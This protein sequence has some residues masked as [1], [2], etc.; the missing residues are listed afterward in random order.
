VGG[1]DLG[2]RVEPLGSGAVATAKGAGRLEV[3]AYAVVL[4]A[5]GLVYRA[6]FISQGFNATD[7]GW[8]QAVAR[9][10]VMGQV[11]YRDFNFDF[12]P[13]SIYKEAGLQ[14]L[15]GAAYD[16]LVSR[17]AFA[18]EA[19]LGSVLAFF[20]LRSFVST[21]TAFLLALPTNFFSVLVYAYENYTY[22][23]QILLL[24]SLLLLQSAGAGRRWLAVA[25]GVAA[26]LAALAKPTYAGFVVL[27]LVVALAGARLSPID[28]DRFP[29]LLGARRHWA[30][31]LAGFAA[32][33]GAA[34]LAFTAVGAGGAFVYQSFVYYQQANPLGLGFA[35]WQN[36]PTAFSRRELELLV[37]IAVLLVGASLLPSAWLRRLCALGTPL[38]LL[39]YFYRHHLPADFVPM[40]MGLLLIINAWAVVLTIVV[41]LPGLRDGSHFT[42][43]RDRL[44]PP[45]LPVFALGLQYLAQ[46]TSSGVLYSY[47]GAYLS[48]PTA[49][50]LLLE[51][52]VSA[53]DERAP[54]RMALPALAPALFALWLVVASVNFVQGYVYFDYPRSQLTDSFKTPALA[55]ITS[56][57]DNVARVDGVVAA[58]DRHSRPGDPIFALPDFACLYLLADRRNPTRQDWYESIIL[59]PSIVSQAVADLQRDPPKVVVVQTRYEQDYSHT[60][61]DHFIDYQHT[62]ATQIYQYLFAN[63]HV[64]E[65]VGDINI[66]VPNG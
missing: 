54:A 59:T 39:A 18:V 10:I 33:L 27:V 48:V 55:G 66:L 44:P 57:P 15:F 37:A 7:E 38:G 25:A 17:W 63:Y 13:L 35:I 36:L 28:A 6:T 11:P 24:L 12:P 52:A 3:G 60:R 34:S 43:L 22:D 40:A 50:I 8:L 61:T 5:V 31:F 4:L 42:A 2:S 53:P 49:L 41:R 58:V 21:R 64:V 65:K 23:G 30:A 14:V 32:T 16:L 26:G 56:N 20:I 29:A 9:R 51:V 47:L 1:R 62:Q 19:G 46:F 45:E